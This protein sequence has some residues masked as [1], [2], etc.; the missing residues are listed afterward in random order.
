MTD[1][2]K[3]D[4]MISNA[5]AMLKALALTR[6][7]GVNKTHHNLIVFNVIH[8]LDVMINDLKELKN[9]IKKTEDCS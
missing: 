9:D 5:K 7:R 3:L 6:I 4:E 8:N 2:K 1:E